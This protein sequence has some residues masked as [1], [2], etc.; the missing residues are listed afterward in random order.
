MTLHAA[1][2]ALR[3]HPG[4]LH[5]KLK[6]GDIPGHKHGELPGH[7]DPLSYGGAVFVRASDFESMRR[8]L[9]A[10]PQRGPRHAA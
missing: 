6:A 10:P 1:A 4:T 5:K 7:V 8:A 9:S 2:T 3:I